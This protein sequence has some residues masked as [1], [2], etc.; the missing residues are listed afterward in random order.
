MFI[1]RRTG[2]SIVFYS[3]TEYYQADKKEG[4]RSTRVRLIKTMKEQI[5]C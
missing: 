2:E 4:T 1:S 5:S 3:V